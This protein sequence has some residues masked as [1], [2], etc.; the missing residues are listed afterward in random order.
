MPTYTPLFRVVNTVAL[1][2]IA[3]ALLAGPGQA[4]PPSTELQAVTGGTFTYQGQLK[5]RGQPANATCAF[6]FSLWN[7]VTGGTQRGT[8]LNLNTVRVTQGLFTV[9]LNFGNPF[10][11][12]ALWLQTSVRCDGEAA[13][14]TLTPRQPL[15]ATPYALGLVPGATVEGS[16]NTP[17]L[18]VN[19]LGEGVAVHGSATNEP[20][21][22]GTSS[23]SNGV[24]GVSSGTGAAAGVYGQSTGGRGVWGRST[25]GQGVYGHSISQAGVFGESQ[26]FD[27]GFF[28]SQGASAAGVS[29]HN[30]AGGMGVFGRSASGIG[31]LGSSTTGYAFRA[32]GHARQQLDKGGWAKLMVVVDYRTASPVVRCFNSQ[33]SGSAATSVPCDIQ[34][35][36]IGEGYWRINVGFDVTSRFAVATAHATNPRACLPPDTTCTGL[37]WAQVEYD[38]R[39]IIVRTINY[40]GFFKDAPF[41]LIVY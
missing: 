6:Q 8:T 16:A 3:G 12:E 35:A 40:D 27:G 36:R 9:P 15:T 39:T 10:T 25:S 1:V 31:V 2:L 13:F 21:V 7:A 37:G 11:G 5:R 19:N 22:Y 17:T 29:G 30:E 18:R 26:G 20:G 33:L 38:G 34:A 23:T 28:R 41:T 32:D 24:S 14:T 4:A